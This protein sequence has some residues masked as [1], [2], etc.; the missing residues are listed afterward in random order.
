MTRPPDHDPMRA[1]D[2][3]QPPDQWDDIVARSA[4]ADVELAPTGATHHLYRRLLV[5]AVVLAVLG[6]TGVVALS[7]RSG[8]AKDSEAVTA[9]DGGSPR[10]SIPTDGATGP[11]ITLPDGSPAPTTTIGSKGGDG[12]PSGGGTGSG[13]GSG[14]GTGNGTGGGTGT[15]GNGNH[16]GSTTTPHRVT[17]TTTA[18]PGVS[19]T[20]APTTTAPVTTTT[21]PN[22]SPPSGGSEGFWGHKWTVTALADGGTSR[23]L[24]SRAMVLDATSEGRVSILVCNRLGGSATLEG[25]QLS[26]QLDPTTTMGCGEP[27]D[28]NEALVAALLQ[29]NPTVSV[30][31]NHL[32]LTSGNRKA[33][34]TS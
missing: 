30:S 34:L 19:S 21:T 23:S 18:V 3:V 27:I 13:S 17:T 4:T 26:V 10:T 33:E 11:V 32:T 25:D 22:T 8:D 16:S 12:S 1:L 5:A 15:G 9:T 31:D 24:G 7:V 6:L 2:E 20:T 29:G 28:G 14:T